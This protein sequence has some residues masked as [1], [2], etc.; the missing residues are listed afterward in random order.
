[1]GSPTDCTSST[2]LGSQASCHTHSV[3]RS[4]AAASH[5]LLA[6]ALRVAVI[7]AGVAGLITARALQRAGIDFVVFEKAACLAGVWA[8]A[9]HGCS[10]QGQLLLLTLCL[11]WV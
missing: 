2:Q 11:R 5:H 1:M 3:R 9:T 4:A 7:G 10:T 8:V 6:G